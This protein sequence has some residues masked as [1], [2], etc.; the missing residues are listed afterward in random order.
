MYA[1]RD[2]NVYQKT[3]DGWSSVDSPGLADLALEGDG[4]GQQFAVRQP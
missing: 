2:G 1:G 3:D 4:F